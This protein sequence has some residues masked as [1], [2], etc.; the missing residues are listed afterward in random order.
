MEHALH[1]ATFFT[2]GERG[3]SCTGRLCRCEQAR[4]LPDFALPLTTSRIVVG[5]SLW[6]IM[7]RHQYVCH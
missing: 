1:H 2:C 7:V 4:E 5:I 3:C 6:S